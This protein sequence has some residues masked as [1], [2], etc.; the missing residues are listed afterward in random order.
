MNRWKIA[1][2]VCLLCLVLVTAFGIYA[3][4]DQGISLT[5]L[6]DDY[7]KT[8]SDLNSLCK[9]IS[10]TDLAKTEIKDALNRHPL[11]EY[12]DFNADTV[13]L[14]RVNLIF[15]NNKLVSVEKQN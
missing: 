5:Y 3:I 9:I 12:M 10:K 15:Q 6:N 4:L 11:F 2:G 7:S 14:D 13:S 1:V 8:E